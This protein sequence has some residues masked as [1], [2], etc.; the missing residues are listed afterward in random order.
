MKTVWTRLEV[1]GSHSLGRYDV[2]KSLMLYLPLCLEWGSE[3]NDLIFWQE[4]KKV[5][6]RSQIFAFASVYINRLMSEFVYPD[7]LVLT[8]LQ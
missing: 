6:M 8:F 4:G 2:G 5:G 7:P 1:K 3:Y